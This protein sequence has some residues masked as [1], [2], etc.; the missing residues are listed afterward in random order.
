M[1][2]SG[3]MLFEQRRDV[4]LRH[5]L[6][7]RLLRVVRQVLEDRGGVLARQHAE[8]DD[9]VLE[10]EL[11]QERRRGRWRAGCAPCRAAAR[12][13]ARGRTAASSSA[14]RATWRIDGQRVVA[15][16]SVQLLFHLRERGPDDVVVVHVRADRPSTRR[17]TRGESDR[18]R[19]A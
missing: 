12:S 8:D 1:R 13:R 14:G 5:R 7:Q 15:L 9:L 11:G 10:A 18:D 16:W 17:A 3:A 4:F 19:A 2:S 6:E